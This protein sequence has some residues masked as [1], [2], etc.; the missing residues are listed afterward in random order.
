MATHVSLQV[1]EL[2]EGELAAFEI[3]SVWLLSTMSSTM[4][5]KVS[6]LSEALVA[7]RSIADISLPRCL[8]VTLR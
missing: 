5:V 8:V 7:V 6:L 3:T 4:D 1:S 2:R